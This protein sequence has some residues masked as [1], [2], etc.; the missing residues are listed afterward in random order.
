MEITPF[1]EMTLKTKKL[2]TIR[3]IISPTK[4]H[5]LQK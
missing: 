5:L 1:M 3:K 4:H 2:E